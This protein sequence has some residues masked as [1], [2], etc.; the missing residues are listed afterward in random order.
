MK[1]RKKSRKKTY[2]IV[3]HFQSSLGQ[4]I[5]RGLT[6]AQAKKHCQDPK[7]HDMRAPNPWFDGFTED[8]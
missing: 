4:T 7:T 2:K 5:K 8:K 3:R 6:L 1:K